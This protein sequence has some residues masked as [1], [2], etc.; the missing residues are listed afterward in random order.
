M[1]IGCLDQFLV[2]LLM[3][4]TGIMVMGD[5]VVIFLFAV[6]VESVELSRDD[7]TGAKLAQ[8]VM[9]V[10]IVSGYGEGN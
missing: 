9:A 8:H 6:D 2:I 3:T 10:P 7:I 1:I 5:I 4:A